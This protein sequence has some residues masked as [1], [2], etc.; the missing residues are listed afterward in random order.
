MAFRGNIETFFFSSLL[1]LLTNDRKT[2]VLHIEKEKGEVDVFIKEGSIVNA[3]SSRSKNRL[4]YLLR[5]KGII[6]SEELE[7]SLAISKEN[8]QKLGK[9]LVENKHITTEDLEKFLNNQV[10]ETIHDLFI[11]EKGNFEFKESEFDTEKQVVTNIDT[12]GIILEASRR[13]DEISL[14]K[15]NLPDEKMVLIKNAANT[16]TDKLNEAERPVLAL[17]NG[18]R[19]LRE[20]VI[21]SG[22]DQHS[23]YKII[24]SLISSGFVEVGKEI[25]ELGTSQQTTESVPIELQLELELVPQE[26]PQPESKPDVPHAPETIN[27][28]LVPQEEPQP[29]IEPGGEKPAETIIVD[30]DVEEELTQNKKIFAAHKSTHA[31]EMGESTRFDPRETKSVETDKDRFVPDIALVK[32]TSQSSNLL[33]P[34]TNLPNKIN[35]FVL[36]AIAIGAVLIIM[37]FIFR[38]DNKATVPSIQPQKIKKSE[39]IP[40]TKKVKTGARKKEKETFILKYRKYSNNILSISIPE[41]YKATD[42]SDSIIQNILFEYGKNIKIQ[43]TS[44]RQKEEWDPETMMY[45]KIEEIQQRKDGSHSLMANKYN[46]INVNRCTGYEIVMSGIRNYT[47]SRVYFCALSCKGRMFIIDVDCKKSKDPEVSK[48]F[49]NLKGSMAKSLIVY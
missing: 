9:V 28:D 12:L 4:G 35:L 43:L 22:Y 13:V 11:W 2:G 26:E 27:L 7:N 38:P 45:T 47:F 3:I 21:E 1:Q 20:I 6:T 17:I 30:T 42:K 37:V 5:T 39:E 48:I 10:E 19:T 23:A 25:Q 24:Y 32:G 36:G 14:L 33:S 29:D 41:G 8:G 16:S 46:L 18:K 31:H 40:A 49:N 15:N 44:W 34:S